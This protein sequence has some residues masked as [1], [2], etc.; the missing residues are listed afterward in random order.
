MQSVSSN[1]VSKALSYSTTEHKTGRYWTDGKPTY[2]VTFT[3]R[4]TATDISIPHNIA[5][6]DTLVKVAP[7]MFADD[8]GSIET[9]FFISNVYFFTAFV[10][11]TQILTRTTASYINTH[12]YRVTFEYTKTTD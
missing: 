7:T 3:G 8:G 12:S 1:A 5:N 9:S 6:I 2:E 10:T 4:L 11:K